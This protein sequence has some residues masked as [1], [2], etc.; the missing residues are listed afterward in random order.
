MTRAKNDMSALMRGQGRVPLWPIPSFV[1]VAVAVVGSLLVVVVG[2]E[3]RVR[4]GVVAT[5]SVIG[6][7]GC[8][9]LVG[10]VDCCWSWFI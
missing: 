5:I 6:G 8:G 10:G 4:M 3:G 1:A 2:E 7:F 9:I